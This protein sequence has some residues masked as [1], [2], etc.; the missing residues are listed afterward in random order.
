MKKIIASPLAPKAVGPYSQA[1]EAAGTIYVSG[2]LPID[3]STGKMPEGIEAQTRQSLTNLRHILEEAGSSLSDVVKT[4][5]LLQDMGDF[6][7][8][9]AVYAEF[10]TQEMPARMCYEVARLP[11]GA[12]V[13]IDAVA[14]R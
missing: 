3:A 4:T 8:M 12:Q 11:M 14:V 5:V 7:A 1:V 6:A 10:F 9:N 2:Q 13:E